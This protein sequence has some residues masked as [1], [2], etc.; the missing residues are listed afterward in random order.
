A[1]TQEANIIL[2]SKK[3]GRKLM[4]TTTEEVA[5]IYT[6]YYLENMPFKG[7][8]IETQ[9]IP[10]RINFKTLKKNIYNNENIYNSKTIFKFII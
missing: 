7:I 3:S 9:E 8:C 2:K 10:N 4:V 1:E 6:G 5:V